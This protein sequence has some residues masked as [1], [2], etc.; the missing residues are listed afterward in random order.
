MKRAAALLLLSALCAG[1][2]ACVPPDHGI[3]DNSGKYGAPKE[4]EG[5]PHE[6][7]VMFVNV[8]KADCAIV[9]VDGRKA[10]SRP[11]P[12]LSSWGSPHWTAR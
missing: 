9:K 8:G 3:T 12:R 10:S 5:E 11:T 4:F 6:A 1:L 2:A 7:S